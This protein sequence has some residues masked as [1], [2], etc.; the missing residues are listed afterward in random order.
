VAFI[1]RTA[2]LAWLNEGWGRGNV[3]F[4]ILYGR[5][6]VGKS[7]LLDEFTA[8]KRHVTYQAVEGTS[9]DH[10]RDLTVSIL[11]CEDDPV[12]RAAPLGNWDAALAY[13]ARLAQT[14]PLVFIFD[15]YQYAA[16]ADP[17]LASRLQRWL[18]REIPDLP[19]Y[20]ILCGSYIRFF[21]DNVL[22]GPLYG[23]NTGAWQL[24]PLGYVE[25]GEF[26]PS[27]SPEDRI[28]AFAVTGGIPHYL[29]QFDPGRSLASNIAHNVLRRGAVLY[30]EAE[31]VMREELRDPRVYYSILRAIDD[32]C[33][34]NNEIEQRVQ[35]SSTRTHLTAYLETL[36]S[37]GFVERHTPVVGGVRRPIW[38]I[39]DQYLRFWFKFILPNR[40]LLD[41]GGQPD[42]LYDQLVAARLDE[43]V[44][45]PT[46]ED[47]CR[48]W[49]RRQIDGGKLPAADAVG[50]W[51]GPVP[52]PRPN[53]PR[54]R[55]EREIE[56][57][58]AQRGRVVLAGEAKWTGA[59]VD[60]ATLNH[61]R[62]VLPHVPGADAETQILLFGRHFATRLHELAQ[63]EKVRLVSV[64]ELFA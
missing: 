58:A 5:R 35:G 64:A 22:T 45:K 47:I 38:T 10:L 16:Q 3:Q 57:V 49:V 46:F 12:L 6:R 28:R 15:E 18:S 61:L 26:F 52:D 23:R 24:A 8:G 40:A 41:R 53:N 54:Y 37:L 43:F 29:L 33:T 25:A 63:S 60:F 11:A 7:R 2:E 17:T 1:D 48:E 20:L 50:A 51:W 56:I 34:T 4:R 59:P 13:L 36:S 9:A 32:G 42:Q 19:L 44:S 55:T 39:A 14:G 31:L 27:W 30:Q 62:Q 21:V